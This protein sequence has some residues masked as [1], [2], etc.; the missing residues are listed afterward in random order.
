MSTTL[1]ALIALA[2]MLVW[3]NPSHAAYSGHRDRSV[4]PIMIACS[5]D[6]DRSSEHSDDTRLSS[7]YALHAI[8]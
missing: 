1:M 7:L 2:T 8:R 3:G 5:A 4:R 6:R